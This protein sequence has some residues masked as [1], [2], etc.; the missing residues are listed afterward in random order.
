MNASEGGKMAGRSKRLQG[1]RA[2]ARLT[3]HLLEPT[4]EQSL[5]DIVPSKAEIS[6]TAYTEQHYI[7]IL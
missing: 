5:S 3:E 1:C 6:T 4:R 7:N 2:A